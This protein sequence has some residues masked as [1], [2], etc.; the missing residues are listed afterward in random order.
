M[1]RTYLTPAFGH[2]LLT[3]ITPQH[4]QSFV[5]RC[6]REMGLAQKTARLLF[7]TLKTML[8]RAKQWGYLGQNPMEEINPPRVEERE[9]DFLHPDEIQLFLKCADEPY[10]TLF[11]TAILTGMRRGELLG[12]QWGDIDWVNGEIRVRRSLYRKTK[13][14]LAEEAQSGKA[15]WRFSTPKSKSGTRAV[16]MSPRLKEALELHRLACP[17]G[18]HDLVFCNKKGGPLQPR[19]MILREFFPALNRAGLRRIRFHDLRHTY[20]SLL[21]AQG[22]NLKFI[23]SQ[24]GHASIQTTLDR[25]AHLLPETQ[26]QAGERLDAL[27]FGRKERSSDSILIAIQAPTGNNRKQQETNGQKFPLT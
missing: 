16:I 2:L 15:S 1:A 17:A 6:Q 5:G 26:R 23:Q 24:L 13:V 12:L 27:V 22:E 10:R 8:K 3:Q 9:T 7:I 14:E 19:N 21:L 25:Y 11:L 4:V 20:T 18:Q